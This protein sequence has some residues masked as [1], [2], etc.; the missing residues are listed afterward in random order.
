MA[1]VLRLMFTARAASPDS[2]DSA[3]IRKTGSLDVYP[4]GQFAK[5]SHRRI[6]DN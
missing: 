6:S 5:P 2:Q 1:T 4:F 3:N